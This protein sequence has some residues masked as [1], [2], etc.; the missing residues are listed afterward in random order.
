MT[1]RAERADT[2]TVLDVVVEDAAA[3]GAVSC[4][5]SDAA[6]AN[7]AAPA[8]AVDDELLLQTGW[9]TARCALSL[10]EAH[11]S[12]KMPTKQTPWRMLLAFAG[13]GTIISVGY[14]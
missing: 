13:C 14:M 8:P 12:I 9:H 6:A 1:G 3:S 10:P 2:A 7:A 5:D 4:K 11:A